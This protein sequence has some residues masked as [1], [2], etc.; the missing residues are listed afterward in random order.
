MQQDKNADEL[1]TIRSQLQITQDTMPDKDMFLSAEEERMLAES[2][3]NEGRGKLVTANAL[4]AT[5]AR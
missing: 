4:R 2:V 1:R 5:L 3:E